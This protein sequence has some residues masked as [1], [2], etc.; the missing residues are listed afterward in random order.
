MES[1]KCPNNNGLALVIF[2]AAA[3]FLLV[4]FINVLNII[5]SQGLLNGLI[6]YANIVWT[7]ESVLFPEYHNTNAALVF[8]RTFIAWLNLDLG[9]ETCFVKGLTAYWNINLVSINY[10]Y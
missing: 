1:A 9:I 10:M 6:F 3:G 2:F 7:Y 5:L 8:L 4:F